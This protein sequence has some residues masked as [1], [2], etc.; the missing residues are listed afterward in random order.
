MSV[1]VLLVPPIL[2]A[3]MAGEDWRDKLTAVLAVI[4][5]ERVA[6]ALIDAPFR[7]SACIV[8]TPATLDVNVA[9]ALPPATVVV[10]IL[11]PATPPGQTLQVPIVVAKRTLVCNGALTVNAKE[12]PRLMAEGEVAGAVMLKMDEAFPDIWIT[13][14]LVAPS[15]AAVSVS[16]PAV[17]AVMLLVKTPEAFVVPVVG[18]SVIVPSPALLDGAKVTVAPLTALPAASFTVTEVVVEF[19]AEIVVAPSDMAIDDPVTRMGTC[20]SAAP[21]A[22]AVMVAVRLD[23][24]K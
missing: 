11:V 17:L 3:T 8:A 24:S 10:Q 7:P 21:V 19:P 2:G 12:L 6:V 22:L 18:T 23:L 20:T 9:L 14:E 1:V 15:A 5:T 16:A 13:C 4:P